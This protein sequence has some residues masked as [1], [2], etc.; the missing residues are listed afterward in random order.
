MNG[1]D[2]SVDYGGY[3][4]NLP[5]RP[6]LSARTATCPCQAS[7]EDG[8]DHPYQRDHYA[9]VVGFSYIGDSLD[10][11][12][13]VSLDLLFASLPLDALQIGSGAGVSICQII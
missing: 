3:C 4:P 5:S 7:D 11:E 1:H 9:V 6:Q 13:V 10:L 8:R 12:I 2:K